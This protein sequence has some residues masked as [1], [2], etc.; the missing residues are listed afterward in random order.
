MLLQVDSL[1]AGYGEME[2]LHGV[3]MTL[4]EGELVTIIGPNGA[5]K[6]TLVKAMFGLIRP[7]GGR[8]EFRGKDITGSAP[9]DLVMMGLGYVPQ[10]RNKVPILPGLENLANDGVHRRSFPG[11][12]LW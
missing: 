11:P 6:S 7:T 9:R 2:I 3:S 8:V 10:S 12:Y 5:G 1:H 4:D